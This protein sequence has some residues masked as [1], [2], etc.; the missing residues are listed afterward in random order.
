[1][2]Q[3]EIATIYDYNYWANSRILNAASKVTE[4]QLVSHTAFPFGSLRGTLVHTMDAEYSWRML[5]ENAHKSDRW[6]APELQ[7]KDFPTL[8]SI[9]VRWEAEESAMRQYVAGLNDDGMGQIIRYVTDEGYKRERP[10][11]H[12]LFHVVNH[13]SQ[14]RSEAAAMLT[15]FGA[16]PGE[17]DFTIF[18][19]ERQ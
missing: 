3:S 4:E 8:D 15:A 19:N 1:M 10:L 18:M 16:S 9:M 12:C 6:E 5:L 17:L 11:W 2:R 7:E 13:G 14:H